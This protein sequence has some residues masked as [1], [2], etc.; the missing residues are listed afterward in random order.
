MCACEHANVVGMAVRGQV[1]QDEEN[2][3]KKNQETGEKESALARARAARTTPCRGG[4]GGPDTRPHAQARARKFRQRSR[5]CN[6]HVHDVV[7]VVVCMTRV[8]GW[9]IGCMGEAAGSGEATRLTFFFLE[10]WNKK[11]EHFKESR[12]R[13]VS[14]NTVIYIQKG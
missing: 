8:G 3:D 12:V 9:R 10:I 11:D 6:A 2:E 14:L 5:G 13:I 1:Q 7:H 4:G